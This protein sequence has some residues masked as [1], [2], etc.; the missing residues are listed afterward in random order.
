ME[1]KGATD[2]QLRDRSVRSLAAAGDVTASRGVDCFV[3]RL[4]VP[5]L[6]VGYPSLRVEFPVEFVRELTDG[7]HAQV[8]REPTGSVAI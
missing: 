7:T 3:R 4:V 5:L 6:P 2:G 8:S 1:R